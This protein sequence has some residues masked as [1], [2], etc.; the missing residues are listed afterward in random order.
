MRC[1]SLPLLADENI[2]PGVVA[3]LRAR[4]LDVTSVVESG[5][6]GAEDVAV[7]RCAR[8]DGRVV[9]THDAD[10]GTLAVRVG[11]PIVGIIYLRP[12][13]IATEFV[14]GILDALGAI[15]VEPPFI[16]VAE[17]GESEVRV[18]VRRLTV[19]TG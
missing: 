14:I 13:H 6:C 5:L 15:E 18:R 2:H 9:V 11:E 3:A 8:A 10:F 1:L 16:L 7:L 19:A 12:G 17:R 4:G